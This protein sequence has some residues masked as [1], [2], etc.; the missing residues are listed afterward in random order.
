M[1]NI[2]YVKEA[3]THLNKCKSSLL[4]RDDLFR[5]QKLYHTNPNA[6]VTLCNDQASQNTNS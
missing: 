3:T 6:E 2:F 1:N 4:N 5:Y